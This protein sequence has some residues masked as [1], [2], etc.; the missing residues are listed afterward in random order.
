[1]RNCTSCSPQLLVCVPPLILICF[2]F[3]S[4]SLSL[5]LCFLCYTYDHICFPLFPSCMCIYV[6]ELYFKTFFVALFHFS[7]SFLT[8]TFTLTLTLTS[9]L[10]FICHNS[11]SFSWTFCLLFHYQNFQKSS[12]RLINKRNCISSLFSVSLKSKSSERSSKM[13]TDDRKSKERRIWLSPLV[14]NMA[15]EHESQTGFDLFLFSLFIKTG[16]YRKKR[17]SKK[18]T[19]SY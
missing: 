17:H 10:P 3:L 1:M 19:L 8:F 11:I 9:H 16:W 13:I 7:L 15:R 12:T 14:L 2:H 18:T 4:L 6:Y 5:S